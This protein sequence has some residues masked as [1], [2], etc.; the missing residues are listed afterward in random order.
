MNLHYVLYA[1][2]SRITEL[3]Y[4]LDHGQ[5]PWPVIYYGGTVTCKTKAQL[6]FAAN[7]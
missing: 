3:K 6:H 1:R 4:L 2:V 7:T 5:T